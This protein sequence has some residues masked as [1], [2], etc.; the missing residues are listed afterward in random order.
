MSQKEGGTDGRGLFESLTAGGRLE[1]MRDLVSGGLN[2]TWL[3]PAGELELAGA[4]SSDRGSRGAAASASYGMLTRWASLGA[5][6]RWMSPAYANAMLRSGDDRPLAHAEAT[7]SVSLGRVLSLGALAGADWTRAGQ[8]SDRAS[9]RANISL[10]AN[11]DLLLSA[12][13]AARAT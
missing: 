5:Q 3:T 13:R 2:T 6:V 8:R 7:A 9:L 4:L 10:R 1:A 12:G 11:L